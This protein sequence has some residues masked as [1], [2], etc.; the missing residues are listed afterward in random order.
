MSATDFAS[1]LEKRLATLQLKVTEAAK[2]SGLSRQSWYKLLNAEVEEAKISTL[3]KVA[4]TLQVP[5]EHLMYLYFQAGS[6]SGL[7]ARQHAALD[8]GLGVHG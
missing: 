1:Y 3:R 2:R 7:N 6:K 5:P 8:A 4:N